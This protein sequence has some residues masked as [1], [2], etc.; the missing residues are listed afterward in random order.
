MQRM[1]SAR[2]AAGVPG[3]TVARKCPLVRWYSDCASSHSGG[4]AELS[5]LSPPLL[6]P[7]RAA[8]ASGPAGA[9][10][11]WGESS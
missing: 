6:L 1:M 7:S 10:A 11:G 5:V 2:S 4:L 9:G 3:C 8:R